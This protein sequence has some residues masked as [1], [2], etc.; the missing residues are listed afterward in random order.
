MK[1][2]EKFA[3]EIISIIKRYNHKETMLGLIWKKY[4]IDIDLEDEQ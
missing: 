4:N 3:R 1:N 2:K